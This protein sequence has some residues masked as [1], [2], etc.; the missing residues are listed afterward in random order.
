MTNQ[1]PV[2]RSRDLTSTNQRPALPSNLPASGA[3]AAP[4]Q[5]SAT[6][7]ATLTRL[8]PRLYTCT[9]GEVTLM[10]TEMVN[11]DNLNTHKL[12]CGSILASAKVR[13]LGPSLTSS[14]VRDSKLIHS[15]ID[16][17]LRLECASWNIRVMIFSN[18]VFPGP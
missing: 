4:G 13:L 2:L 11:L 1:R 5:S 3:G 7:L 12:K 18:V 17:I 16:H 15:I 6:P 8:P 14:A 10:R 9:Q